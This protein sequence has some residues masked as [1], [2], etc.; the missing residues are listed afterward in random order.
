[1]APSPSS[2]RRSKRRI[3]LLV[4]AVVAVFAILA[5][6][7]TWL[8]AVRGPS[9]SATADR[10]HLIEIEL[11]APRGAITSSDG[12]T[13]AVDRPTVMVTADAR[14]VRDPAEVAAT[15]TSVTRGKADDRRRLEDAL[16][17]RAAYV[18]LAKHVTQKQA[19]YLR[20]LDMDGVH[21]ERTSRRDYPMGKVAGQVLGFTN[22]DTGRGIEGVE[23][24]QDEALAGTAGTRTEIR[25][26]RLGET[27][28]LLETVDPEPGTSVE[29]AINSAVQAKLEDV[30]AAARR[31]YRAKGAMGLVMDPNTGAILAM[32]SVPRVDPNDRESLRPESVRNRAV[33]DPYEPGSVFK[34]ITIAGALEERLT[35]PTEVWNVPPFRKI[36]V[37]TDY[38]WTLNEAHKRTTYERMTTTEILQRSSNNGTVDISNRLRKRNHLRLWMAK[39]GFGTATGV[40]LAAEDRGLLPPV[41]KWNEAT[42]I[43]IPIGQGLTATNVQLARAYAAIANGGWLVTPHVTSRVGGHSVAPAR[44]ERILSA[45]TS[46][47]LTRM[48]ENV[49]EGTDGTG[50]QASLE[51]YVVAGKTGT[52]QKVNP[53][54]GRYSN[55]RFYSSFIGFVPS[56]KPRLL[57]SIMVDEPD[58]RGPR[59]GG[60]VAAPA[61]R[62][63]A[64]YAL[65][66]LKIPPA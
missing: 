45:R 3:Q 7:A 20:G 19:D 50:V 17:T 36:G 47:Q 22:L 60:D 9:L 53:R 62:E 49:V 64:D 57:I 23:A 6:R 16:R 13:L 46:R 12:L 32:T 2:T 61:F 38:V 28:R 66:T 48:L 25:D 8:G 11:P 18:V 63:V 42:R 29:L 33:T 4:T 37:G 14:Y 31:R 41:A 1:M 65:S 40:D 52:A 26:P 59:T 35:T 58:P 51:N 55:D 21:F 44:G 15:I 5:V 43:N 34:V 54:T 39:F 56:Q 30:L 27:V 10:Q 24:R